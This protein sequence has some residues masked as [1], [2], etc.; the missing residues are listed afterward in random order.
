MKGDAEL[1]VENVSVYLLLFEK[2]KPKGMTACDVCT[3]PHGS[4]SLIF[5]FFFLKNKN[6]K[7][8]ST[9]FYLTPHYVPVSWVLCLPVWN[10]ETEAQR[11]TSQDQSHS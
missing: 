8:Y 7:N 1:Q 5:F 2:N 4:I 3:L 11:S 10:E 9:H 6:K